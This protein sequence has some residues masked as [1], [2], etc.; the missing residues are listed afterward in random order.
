MNM[1]REW[2]E[3]VI[4]ELGI[5]DAVTPAAAQPLTLD[6]AKDVAHRVARPAAPLTTYLLG[7][8]VGRSLQP[9]QAAPELAEALRRLAERWSAEHPDRG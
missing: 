2:S 1:L 4:R 5:A 9:A 6:L 7:V 8:A 3:A